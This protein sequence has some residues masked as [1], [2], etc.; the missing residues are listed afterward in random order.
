MPFISVCDMDAPLFPSSPSSHLAEQWLSVCPNPSVA[1]HSSPDLAHADPALAAVDHAPPCLESRRL[2][3][4]PPSMTT[5]GTVNCTNNTTS[6]NQH[7]DLSA[8]CRPQ[9]RAWCRGMATAGSTRLKRM[10]YYMLY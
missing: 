4:L 9:L 7:G 3:R 2:A 6:A 10:L 8:W 5:V 1:L